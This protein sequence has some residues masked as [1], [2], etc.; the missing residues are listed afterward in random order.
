MLL[1]QIC[2]TGKFPHS[3]LAF[4]FLFAAN[5]ENLES[6]AS[7]AHTHTHT[8]RAPATSNETKDKSNFSLKGGNR[9]RNPIKWLCRIYAVTAWDFRP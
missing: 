9:H 4:D 3:E 2:E 8:R 7:H 1:Q 5:C 6:H